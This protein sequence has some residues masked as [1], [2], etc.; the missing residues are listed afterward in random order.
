MIRAVGPPPVPA[1]ILPALP[2]HALL[3]LWTELAALLLLARLLGSLARR[4]HQPPVLGELVAGLLLGPSV[5]GELAPAVEHWF[6]PAGHTQGDLLQT[7]S[8]FSLL[9]LLVVVG[10]ETDLPLIRRLG[11]AAASVSGVSLVL[12]LAAGAAAALVLPSGFQVDGSRQVAFVVLMAGAMGVSSL[13]VVAKIIGD[14]G[15]MR[16]SFAQM[17]LAAGTANDVTGFVIAAVAT[18][19]ARSGSSDTVAIAL[20]GLAAVTV[21]TFSAGQWSIDAALRQVRRHGPNP[22][23][24]ITVALVA[25][26]VAAAAAQAFGIEG[27]LGGFLAGIALGRSRFQQGAA[28]D[29]LTRFTNAVLAP[30][31]FATA[32]LRVDLATL[33]TTALLV[34][35]GAVV[36]GS[37]VVKFLAALA[38]ARLARL[39]GREGSALGVVLNGRGTL[40]IIIAGVGLSTGVFTAAGYTAVIVLALVS[41]ISVAPLL[42]AVVGNWRGSA[43]EQA[44]LDEEERLE[45]NLVVRGGRILLAS[46]G[47]PSALLAAAVVHRAWPQSAPVTV[48]TV[49]RGDHTDAA[50]G[51]VRGAGWMFPGRAI[52]RRRVASDD[53]LQTIV[54]ETQL[55]YGVLALG[56]S[57]TAGPDRLLSAVVD[58]VMVRCPIPMVVARRA[59]TPGVPGARRSWAVTGNADGARKSTFAGGEP[60]FRRVLVPVAGSSV[61]S[62]A[63][64]VAYGLA[65]TSR[66]QVSLVHIVTRPT[67]SRAPWA[68]SAERPAQDVV[69]R[70]AREAA[71]YGLRVRT[72]IRRSPAVAEDIVRQASEIDADLVVLGASVRSLDGH[73]FL[74]HTVEHVLSKAS[75]AVV[76]VVLPMSQTSSRAAAGDPDNDAEPDICAEP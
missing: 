71:R 33:D 26:L 62:G 45:A 24:S 1:T 15:L 48:L 56:A 16:R 18:G 51:D 17:A 23:G 32:G 68:R 64:E 69:R 20:G 76:V 73:P 72:R 38:G 59:A 11:P 65:R 8:E 41:S 60:A 14:M 13:P 39:S 57:E 47:R 22:A 53:V 67:T 49:D 27:A 25:A 58:D 31:F 28:M 42:S 36:V 55:G 61:S 46:G 66:A 44:R 50:G 10:A 3:V 40:Q 12:P 30:L 9:V 54:A 7:V 43:E 52:E 63:Q 29:E 6:L 70:A 21:V 74:G 4:F 2:D 35:T 19:L 37:I 75:C 34:A 5:L